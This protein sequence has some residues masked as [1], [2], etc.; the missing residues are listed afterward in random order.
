MYP[1][2]SESHDDSIMLPR[3]MLEW[4]CHKLHDI[5]HLPAAERLRI[6]REAYAIYG[7]GWSYRRAAYMIGISIGSIFVFLLGAAFFTRGLSR[8]CAVRFP[9]NRDDWEDTFL[10]VGIVLMVATMVLSWLAMLRF[11]LRSVVR[12]RVDDLR[13]PACRYN[14]VGLETADDPCVRCPECGRVG[15]LQSNP[16]HGYRVM[17]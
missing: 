9:G 14:L 17:T 7:V 11:Q 16:V 4:A 13:C 2:S 1:V 12:Q 6:V 5:R 3:C 8:W 10:M 15:V